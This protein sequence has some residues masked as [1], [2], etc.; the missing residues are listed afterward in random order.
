MLFFDRTIGIERGCTVSELVQR[1]VAGV[2]QHRLFLGV[3]QRGKFLVAGDPVI[4]GYRL[5]SSGRQRVT[6]RLVPVHRTVVIVDPLHQHFTELGAFSSIGVVVADLLQRNI[7]AVVLV[8]DHHLLGAD[9]LGQGGGNE[10]N[11]FFLDGVGE[12]LLIAGNQGDC[13]V[14]GRNDRY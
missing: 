7:H 1:H 11:L 9:L 13:P 12:Y 3:V 10:G 8:P 14:A 5:G 6:A 4:P 2:V